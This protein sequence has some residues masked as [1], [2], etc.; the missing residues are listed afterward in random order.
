MSFCPNLIGDELRM[1][2]GGDQ[3]RGVSMPQEMKAD[4]HASTT[5]YPLQR[6]GNA[7]NPKYNT[8]RAQKH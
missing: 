3:I 8:V 4:I 5:A 6:Q 1:N 7:A 2:V